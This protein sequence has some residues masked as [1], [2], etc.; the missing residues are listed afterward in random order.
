MITHRCKACTWWDNVHVSVES[1]PVTI[2]K[3]NPGFCR[4]RRPGVRGYEDHHFGVQP[5]MDAEEFCGDGYKEI[6]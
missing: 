4:R 1:I 6:E 5:V 3:P 2:E